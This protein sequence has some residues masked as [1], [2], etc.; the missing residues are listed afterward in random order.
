MSTP[1][2]PTGYTLPPATVQG[3]QQIVDSM[4]ALGLIAGGGSTP[5]VNDLVTGGTTSALTAQQGPA[6]KALIDTNTTALATKQA[7]LVSGNNL[8]TVNGASLLGSTDLAIAGGVTNQTGTLAASAT[9]APVADTVIAALATKAA[10][11]LITYVDV[12]ASRAL[13]ASDLGKVLRNTGATSFTVTLAASIG[14]AGNVF[15]TKHT[16]A[17]TLLVA[18]GGGVTAVDTAGLATA[19]LADG[20]TILWEFDSATRVVAS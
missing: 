18:S 19:Q 16:G 20:A 2:S 11:G 13:L 7:T 4:S 10:V 9:A 5:L 17:G 12:T 6:I 14:V 3:V 1:L 8:R 15:G